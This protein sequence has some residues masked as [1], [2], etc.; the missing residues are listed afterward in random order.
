LKWN[1]QIANNSYLRLLSIQIEF[2]GQL[3][4]IQP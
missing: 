3:S 1:S 4:E 2:E